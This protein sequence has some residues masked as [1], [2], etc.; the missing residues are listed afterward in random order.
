MAITEATPRI[1]SEPKSGTERYDS[2]MVSTLTPHLGA[3][4]E[5]LDLSQ[6]L[7]AP[8][9]HDL[10]QALPTGAFW[11]FET[12]ISTERHTRRSAVTSVTYTCIR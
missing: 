12:S 1:G 6:P 11:C 3:Q 8:Q 7:D 2:F 10:H 4:V 5:G 9:L